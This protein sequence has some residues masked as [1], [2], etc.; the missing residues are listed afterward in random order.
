[1]KESVDM[2]SGSKYSLNF[3]KNLSLQPRLQIKS[4]RGTLDPGR[5]RVTSNRKPLHFSLCQKTS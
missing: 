2:T 5:I 4:E 1:M 3:H